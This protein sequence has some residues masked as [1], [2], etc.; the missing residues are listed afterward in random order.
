MT[1]VAALLASV[2][3]EAIVIVTWLRKDVTTH[4]RLVAISIVPTLLTHPLMWMA[5]RYFV[6]KF[7]LYIAIV[8][9]ELMVIATEGVILRMLIDKSWARCLLISLVANFTSAFFG[10]LWWNIF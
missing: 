9:L 1:Q 8:A 5:S 6:T 10:W 4:A 2:A 3:I 7:P